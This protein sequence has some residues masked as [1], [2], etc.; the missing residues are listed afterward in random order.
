M[1]AEK[2]NLNMQAPFLSATSAP[3]AYGAALAAISLV[4]HLEPLPI[5]AA[6]FALGYAALGAFLVVR[7][8]FSHLDP[9]FRANRSA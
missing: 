4:V 6:P 9:A 1:A 8:D 2:R 7:F 5:I 3:G